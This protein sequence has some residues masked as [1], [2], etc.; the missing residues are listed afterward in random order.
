LAFLSAAEK[1]T[2]EREFKAR[3]ALGAGPNYIAQQ[4]I[5]WANRT[6]ADPRIPEALH[7]AVQTTRY[8]CTDE[9]TGRWSKS[10][11]DLLHRNYPNTSWAKKT[12]YWFNN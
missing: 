2:A 3:L 6:P 4:V 5:Q 12:K 9:Q 10:A 1:A 8:G 7:L 11:F